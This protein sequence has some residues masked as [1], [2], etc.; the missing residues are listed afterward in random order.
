LDLGY[1]SWRV[2]SALG[3]NA[4]DFKDA[5]AAVTSGRIPEAKQALKNADD[6]NAAASAALDQPA[7]ALVRIIP[8]IGDDVRVVDRLTKASSLAVAAGHEALTVAEDLGL[9]DDGL[10]ASIYRNGVVNLDALENSRAAIDK[11]SEYMSEAD[12]LLANSP[13]A[14]LPP[15]RDALQQARASLTPAAD[16]SSKA[17]A[18]F[19][20]LPDLLGGNGE[21]K[22]LL[23][24]QATGEARA[25]GGVI[26]LMGTMSSKNGRVS[27][28]DIG[29]YG[30]LFP[31]ILDKHVPA[32]GWFEKSYGPQY[33][34]S[35]WQQVNSS[36]DF[37]VVAS[38]LQ[39]MYEQKTGTSLDGVIAMDPI[40]LQDMM[41]GMPPV[42]LGGSV[43]VTEDNVADVVL[44]DSYL[45]FST[46]DE[47]NAFLGRLVESFWQR[48]QKGAFNPTDFAAGMAD[49]TSSRHLMVYSDDVALQEKL[50]T[51]GVAGDYVEDGINAQ[52]VFHNAY[53]VS[54]VDYYLDERVDTDVQLS[55]EGSAV[56]T[57]TVHLNN[58]A[59][60]GPPS[61]LLGGLRGD[62]AGLNR[63][64]FNVLA[65]PSSTFESFEV[66]GVDVPILT[67]MDN[68]SPVAWNVIEVGPGDTAEAS[69]TYRVPDAIDVIDG[70][71]RLRLNLVPQPR[72]TPDQYSVVVRAPSGLALA[73]GFAD[74]P[75]HSTYR[76]HGIFDHEVALDLVVV[77][78]R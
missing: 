13:H 70:I 22:Y 47:Q 76:S 7:V 20:G 24:F 67:F 74:A 39:K 35:Q 65:P 43:T 75:S 46:Q 52:V 30:D 66:N 53:T 64:L 8:I 69:V 56:V 1:A 27:L 6:D 5:R 78:P 58:R 36:P 59:P 48:I 3:S 12:D 63:M 19:G 42:D 54:K 50:D 44:H 4:G 14:I 72:T 25:T 21:K 68:T 77:D 32:P 49:A 73:P 51:I 28:G 61:L 17:A 23:A 29:P 38:V 15:V 41:R 71:P 37:P 31:R 62:Q 11:A 18:L 55:R 60:D 2:S 34:T 33:A 9:S 16:S 40:A 10:A 57:T 26:G 45:D